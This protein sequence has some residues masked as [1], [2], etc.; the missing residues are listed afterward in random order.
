MTS[1]MVICSA[2]RFHP[3]MANHDTSN[4]VFYIYVGDYTLYHKDTIKLHYENRRIHC[5]GA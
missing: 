5:S 3:E 2:I 4:L 1:N